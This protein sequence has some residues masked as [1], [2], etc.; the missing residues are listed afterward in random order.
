MDGGAGYERARDRTAG[1]EEG[2]P[3]VERG[4]EYVEDCC[5]PCKLI[6]RRIAPV[7]SSGWKLLLDARR[8]P[9]TGGLTRDV[10]GYGAYRSGNYAVC[11][12]II[13][14]PCESV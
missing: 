7:V 10:T 1:D 6:S 4:G 2:V 12:G 3:A 13:P 5:C 14:V 11:T 9:L 8:A